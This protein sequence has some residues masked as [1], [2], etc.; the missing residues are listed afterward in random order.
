MHPPLYTV[1]LAIPA[2]LGLS[3]PAEQRIFTA[4]LGV[5]TVFLHR[6]PGA[7]ASPATASG[8]SPRCWPPSPPRCGRTTR[9]SASRSLYG[10]LVVLALLA[11]VPRSGRHRT[12][13]RRARSR[14]GWR[15]RRSPAPR[16]SSCSSFI[17]LPAIV[18]VPRGHARHALEDARPP[19]PRVG[20]V[21]VGPWVVRNLT[22]FDEARRCSAPGSGGCCSTGAATPPTTDR[23]SATG[24]TAARSRTTRPTSR[25]RS[26]TCAPARRPST[27][28]SDH[29]ARV[30]IVVAARVGRVFERV[31]AV[32]E[33]ASSTRS[34][35]G[36]VTSRRWAM[37]IGYYLLL[38]WRS[39]GSSCSG[40]AGSRSSRSSRSSPSTTITVALELR[41]HPVPRAGRRRS[42]GARRGRDRRRH[43]LV[44]PPPRPRRPRR[45]RNPNPRH[46]RPLPTGAPATMTPHDRAATTRPHRRASPTTHRPGP[47]HFGAWLGR[48]RGARRGSVRFLN[49][50]LVATRPPTRPATTA[51]SSGATPSTTTGRRT[52]SPRARGSST[53]TSGTSSTARNA[54]APTHPPLYV[55]VPRAV[56]APRPR[57]RHRAPARLVLSSASPTIVGDRPRRPAARPGTPPGSS[58]PGIAARLPR[59]LDQRRHAAVGDPWR[60]S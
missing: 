33:R 39:A 18:L 29:K 8:S 60:S 47:R 26:S 32:P 41:D 17:A 57:Q 38:P 37:L 34:A 16:A 28:S 56:V 3:T 2:K 36:A 52:R 23:S 48:H 1:Y 10:F 7:G 31:P 14:S 59:D 9:C 45:S 53:R 25:R 40:A 27:T 20:I 15:W 51:T 46:R 55:I 50:L 13:A 11:P 24:T 5:G 35:N 6:D 49:V 44:R 58:R 21:I 19:S 42:A 12:L 4:L 43:P 30:P 54:R 22:T